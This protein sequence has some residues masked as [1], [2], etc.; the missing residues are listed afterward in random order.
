MTNSDPNGQIGAFG[1]RLFALQEEQRSLGEDIRELKREAKGAGID[2]KEVA[3]YA[4]LKR[5]GQEKVTEET[6]TRDK[7]LSVLG[8]LD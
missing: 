1:Q 6:E 3:L 7:V 4:R 2:A 8:W 5:R